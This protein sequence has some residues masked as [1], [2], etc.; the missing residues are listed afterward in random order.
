MHWREYLLS[1][2]GRTGLGVGVDRVLQ[3]GC[4]T[5]PARTQA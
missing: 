3:I 4:G 5:D 1:V 2:D